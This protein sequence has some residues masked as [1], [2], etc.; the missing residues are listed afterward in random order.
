MNGE[1]F[2]HL[3]GQTIKVDRGGPHS[4]VGKCIGYGDDYIT[5]LTKNNGLV[6]YK[7][8]H[9]KSIS[10]SLKEQEQI[11]TFIPEEVEQ[12]FSGLDF[13]TMINN[14]FDHQ[15]V[16]IIPENIEGVLDSVSDD[17]IT[18]IANEELIRV[19]MH[20]IRSVSNGQF[21]T[22]EESEETD[23]NAKNQQNSR[24]TNRRK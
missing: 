18:L 5:L 20:H 19:S 17:Y 2:R 24:K 6:V 14:N 10:Q 16:K 12:Q 11:D 7:L 1:L 21:A 3:K 13:K 23:S 22:Q 4:A 9:V 15:W 8:Y